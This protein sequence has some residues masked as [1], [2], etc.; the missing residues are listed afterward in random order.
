MFLLLFTSNSTS[1]RSTIRSVSG[2]EHVILQLW[3]WR[4]SY[5]SALRIFS[6]FSSKAPE[7]QLGFQTSQI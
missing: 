6:L 5:L 1:N 7:Q 2:Y 4:K 3:A